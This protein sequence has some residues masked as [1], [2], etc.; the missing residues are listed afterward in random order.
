QVTTLIGP[1]GVDGFA[2]ATLTNTVAVTINVVATFDTVNANIDNAF[3]AGAVATI[4]LTA[5]VN[6]DVADGA[7]TNQVDDLLEDDN[8]NTI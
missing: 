3:V 1:S 8:G 6:G 2:T 5:Q 4:T 7:D